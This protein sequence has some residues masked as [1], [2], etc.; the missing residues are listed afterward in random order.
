MA[1][2]VL[3]LPVAAAVFLIMAV[4]SASRDD[5]GWAAGTLASGIAGLTFLGLTAFLTVPLLIGKFRRAGAWVHVFEHGAIAERPRGA[6][7]A[8]QLPR[9]TARLVQWRE[10]WEGEW[11]DRI[12]LWITFHLD[13]EVICFDGL[14]P[15]DRSALSDLARALGVAD[16]PDPIGDL[17]PVKAPTPF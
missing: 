16:Q 4:Q 13:G 5:E 3:L 17:H 9:A 12:Q 7:Y 15:T 14:H 10:S 2:G 1:I 11:R 8:W 6:L